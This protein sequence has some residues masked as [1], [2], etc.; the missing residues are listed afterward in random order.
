MSKQAFTRGHSS[1]PTFLS[2]VRDGL[3]VRV[4]VTPRAQ[5]ERV[6]G[7][8]AD[9]D[10]RLRLKIVVTAAAD[11]GRANEAVIAALAREWQLPKSAFAIVAGTT[12]RRN[13]LAVAG[14]TNQL[15]TRLVGWC[16]A[17]GFI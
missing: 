11:R 17:R 14:E 16:R 2:P 3:E 6:D 15:Q 13:T 10:G 7:M 12:D 5:A 9:A 1:L 8:I 4:R